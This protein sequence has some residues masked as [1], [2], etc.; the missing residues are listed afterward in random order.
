MTRSFSIAL[1]FL[2]LTTLPALGHEFWIDPED[3]EVAPGAPLE[4]NLRVGEEFSGAPS[5][6]LPNRFRRFEIAGAAAP[7]PVEGTM[8]DRPALNQAAEEGLAIVLHETK[9]QRVTYREFAKFAAFVAH[10][11]AEWTLDLHRER[12]LPEEGFVEAYTR[13]A[14][15]LVAVG[16]GDGADRPFGLDTEFVALANPYADDVSAGFP[17]RLLYQGAPRPDAQVEIFEKAPSGEVTVRLV[18]TDGTGEAVIPVRAGHR[19]MLD[20]VVLRE[21]AP[22]LA[23]ETG[24]VWESLWANLTFALPAD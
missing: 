9:V 12:G 4:A 6:Y 7:V 5:V 17:V 21:P 3:F 13:H 8:G 11:D 18:R 19:Y 15:S 14:K 20:A 16:A 2:F 10:K 24:A 23:E 1:A 22:Q